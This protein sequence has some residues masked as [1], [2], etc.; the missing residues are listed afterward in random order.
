MG[1]PMGLG[2]V[3]DSPRMRR[4]MGGPWDWGNWEN[5]PSGGVTKEDR[6]LGG[7]P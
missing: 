1:I 7:A 2:S 4:R 6:R 5:P 3:G